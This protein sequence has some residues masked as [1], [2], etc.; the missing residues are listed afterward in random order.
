MV[1]PIQE[2]EHRVNGHLA[3]HCV[4]STTGILWYFICS[5]CYLMVQIL[6][7]WQQLHGNQQ[8]HPILLISFPYPSLMSLFLLHVLSL[9]KHTGHRVDCPYLILCLESTFYFIPCICWALKICQGLF[10]AV[11]MYQGTKRH[12]KMSPLVDCGYLNMTSQNE[13]YHWVV[14]MYV[15]Y[16]CNLNWCLIYILVSLKPRVEPHIFVSFT[17]SDTVTQYISTETCTWGSLCPF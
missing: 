4:F 9:Q 16:V 12:T 8:N 2:K 1:Q 7:C 15:S 6:S 3:K 11:R 17:M 13:L 14:C 10:Q 5:C